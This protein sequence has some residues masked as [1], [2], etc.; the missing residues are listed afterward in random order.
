GTPAESPPG[1]E[2]RDRELQPPGVP[3]RRPGECAG[4][5]V[6]HPPYRI[7]PLAADQRNPH[8]DPGLPRRGVLRMVTAAGHSRM[9]LAA[10]SSA[11]LRAMA[12]RILRARS[13][14]A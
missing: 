12:S 6:F 5:A 9:Y 8:P 4:L 7:G 10:A 3:S 2:R 11:A 1:P 13:S 14:A